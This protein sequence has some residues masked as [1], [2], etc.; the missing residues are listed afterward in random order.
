MWI[1][2]VLWPISLPGAKI[3]LEGGNYDFVSPLEATTSSVSLGERDGHEVTHSAGVPSILLCSGMAA[4]MPWV[5]LGS[6]VDD[7]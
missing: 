6:D 3:I 1:L 4:T 5:G 2:G 7:T